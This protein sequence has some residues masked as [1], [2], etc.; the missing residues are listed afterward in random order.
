MVSTWKACDSLSLS[1]LLLWDWASNSEGRDGILDPRYH[2]LWPPPEIGLYW[3]PRTGETDLTHLKNREL[4]PM[5]GLWDDLYTNANGP[6]KG[7][8]K[9]MPWGMPHI[10]THA[11][12]HHPLCTTSMA[13]IVRLPYI[14]TTAVEPKV[15]RVGTMKAITG[16]LRD[17]PG[18]SPSLGLGGVNGI[19]RR[20]FFPNAWGLSPL[21]NWLL[22]LGVLLFP[23]S[24]W[25]NRPLFGD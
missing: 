14:W 18:V 12:L 10:R 5:L 23:C 1:I 15:I 19:E 6:G 25:I 21:N 16:K 8:G 24:T 3:T 2:G 22:G 20:K 4:G 9:G 13:G 11:L 7:E 17:L